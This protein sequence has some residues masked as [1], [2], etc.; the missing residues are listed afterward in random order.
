[1]DRERNDVAVKDILSQLSRDEAVIK[2]VRKL[3]LRGLKAQGSNGDDLPTRSGTQKAESCS[4]Q[5]AHNKPTVD[6]LPTKTQM[7]CGKT[8]PSS[9]GTADNGEELAFTV[10]KDSDA[11]RNIFST[12]LWYRDSFLIGSAFADRRGAERSADARYDGANLR[13]DNGNTLDNQTSHGINV[14]PKPDPS[15]AMGHPLLVSAAE[16]YVRSVAA[17]DLLRPYATWIASK[18]GPMFHT[19][20]KSLAQSIPLAQSSCDWAMTENMLWVLND[21]EWKD[22]AKSITTK[23]VDQSYKGDGDL[24]GNK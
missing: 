18:N 17:V 3:A 13:G 14:I 7:Q 5:S 24:G 19:A 16:N 8:Q 20:T 2:E 12:V 4:D 21:E 10:A 1:M 15:T 6:D 23:Y 9:T 11:Y 22:F